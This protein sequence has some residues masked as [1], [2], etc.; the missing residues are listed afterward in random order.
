MFIN[1]FDFLILPKE[2]QDFFSLDQLVEHISNYILVH[3]L[4][5]SQFGY[6]TYFICVPLIIFAAKLLCN[7]SNLQNGRIGNFA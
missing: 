7:T 3:T 4:Y 2:W 6:I 5:I 1:I